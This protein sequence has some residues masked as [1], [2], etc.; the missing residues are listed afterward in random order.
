MYRI[1]ALILKTQISGDK[2][3]DAVGNECDD[4]IDGDGF[5]NAVEIAAGTKPWD[6]NSKPAP[7][8]IEDRDGDSVP[9]ST[10]NCPDIANLNQWD[11]DGDGLGNECDDDIDGDGYSNE[12]ELAAGTKVWD[13]LSYPLTNT[14]TNTDTTT[15]TEQ[16]SDGDG[17]VDSEDDCVTPAGD[18]VDARGCTINITPAQAVKIEAEDYDRF[19]DIDGGNEG[20]AYRN[21]DVDIEATSDVG[22]GFNIGWT[23]AGEWLEYDVNLIAGDYDVLARVASFNGSQGYSISIDGNVIASSSVSATG[24]WQAFTTLNSGTFATDGGEHTI[25]VEF[26]DGGVNLNW[27]LLEPVLPSLEEVSSADELLVAGNDALKPGHTLYVF[28]NDDALSNCYDNCA[29]NWPPVL[30][31]DNKASGINGL[32]T[33]TRNDGS[34]Q[35]TYNG[36]PLYYFAGDKA[37]GDVNGEGLGGVWWSVSTAKGGTDQPGTDIPLGEMKPLFGQGTVLE[38]VITFDRGDA[39]VTRISDRGRDRHAK[40]NHFQ[41]Y[42]H[43]LT[44]YWEHRTAGIEI[45]DY[46]AKGGDSIRMNVTT[47]WRLHETQAE[48]RWWYWGKNTLAEYCGNG[49]MNEIDNRHYWKEETWNCRER[50][51]IQIGDKLEFEM[52]QFLEKTLPRGRENYYGTTYLYIVGEGL[53]PWDTVQTGQHQAGVDFQRDSKKIPEKAW[54]GGNTTIHAQETAEPDGHYMQMANNLGFDNAQPWVLGRRVHHTSFVDGS[55]DE[56]SENGTW[57]EMIGKAGTH[58]VNQRCTDCHERNGAAA[59]APIGEPLDRWVFKVGDIDGNPDAKVG[60]VLQPQSTSGAS[61]GNVSIASWTE[62][63]GLRSPNYQFTNGEPARFSARIAPRLVGL[64]LLEAIPEQSILALADENDAD[65]DGISG[66]AQLSKDPVTGETRLGRFGW[67]A[68]TSSV[69]HQI[70]AALNTDMGV[71]TSVLPEPDCGS[72]QTNCGLSG[73]EL[74]DTNLDNLVKYV[75]L[76]GVRPQRNYDDASVELGKSLF[77]Q[78]GCESCH[79]ETHETSEFAPFAELRGQTIHPY[80]DMLLHDMGEGLADNLGEGVATGAEWRTTPLWGLGTQAC[81]TGGVAGNRGWDAFGLDGHE[82]CTPVYSY[83]HDGRARTIEEAILWHGGESQASN[84]AY[85]ALSSSDKQAV[86]SFLNSL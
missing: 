40:E 1:T 56:S 21:D 17:V 33:I 42:D 29:V 48:N 7:A 8:I 27:L 64:G 65:G 44:F 79:T 9:N 10:D 51:K 30:V 31:T 73:S 28:D 54:L 86:L 4:D 68:A 38:P 80:S 85:Q 77:K 70:A 15:T 57:S 59:P 35:A 39:L 81:V 58:Y 83:L 34:L 71:M 74:S 13:P 50:R 14:D 26:N 55:H 45:V 5:S 60:R 52:S 75:S 53:V 47:Q 11:K 24:G 62:S 6:P 36:R 67:K 25:R 49:V 12:E 2:D 84:N 43:F 3:G 23:E 19:F 66:K 61:E 69:K 16:D 41:A 76:L 20:L 18:T 63:N 72:A 32:N 22:G 37:I 78:I 82:Y 46:V